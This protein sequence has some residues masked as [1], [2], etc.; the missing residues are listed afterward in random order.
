MSTIEA[1]IKELGFELPTPGEPM[2]AYVP[3]VRTGNLVFI[4]GQA[5]V[6]DGSMITGRVGQNLTLEQGYEAAQY[7]VLNGLAQLKKEIGSLDNVERIVKVLGWV[8]CTEDFTQQP[9]V[10]NGASEL[11]EKIF[12]DKGK[13]A[14]SAVSAHV[15]P[16][17]IAV[18]VEM[19]VQVK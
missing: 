18:E 13:H 17:N 15:L 5:P 9:Q 3:V 8:N 14:R 6:K 19:I 10:M 12:G 1:K 11:L 4:S 2:A 7:C 16:L